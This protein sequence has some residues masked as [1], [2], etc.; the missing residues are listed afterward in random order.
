MQLSLQAEGY[1]RHASEDEWFKAQL[2]AAIRAETAVWFQD[3]DPLGEAFD[4]ALNI[5][6]EFAHAMSTPGGHGTRRTP[7]A[8]LGVPL[9]PPV[10]TSGP[11]KRAGIPTEP[12]HGA[13]SLLR[14]DGTARE[15]LVRSPLPV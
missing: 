15:T 13:S 6:P 8:S 7:R 4:S 10:L 3:N 2:P 1:R 11:D 12:R 9:G 14:K 5:E